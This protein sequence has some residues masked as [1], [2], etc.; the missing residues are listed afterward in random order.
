MI[1]CA[2]ALRQGEKWSNVQEISRGPHAA[3]VL[4]DGRSNSAEAGEAGRGQASAGF[5]PGGMWILFPR[6]NGQP[7]Q[8]SK[9]E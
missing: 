2:K 8:A 9:L 3:G 7:L 1:E 6:S 5:S 4:K